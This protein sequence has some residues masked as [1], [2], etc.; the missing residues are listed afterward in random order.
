MKTRMMTR[1]MLRRNR[2]RARRVMM[3]MMVMMKA[4]LMPDTV[5]GMRAYALV[6]VNV[7][8]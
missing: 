6:S 5:L 4:M 3:V 1:T 8:N 7:F 2:T